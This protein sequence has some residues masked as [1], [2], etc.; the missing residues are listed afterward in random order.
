MPLNILLLYSRQ[1]FCS[2][3]C[4]FVPLCKLTPPELLHK[5]CG[6]WVLLHNTFINAF[7]SLPT[8]KRSISQ[9]FRLSSVLVNS[10]L[11]FHSLFLP[12]HCWLM[13]CD[14]FWIVDLLVVLITNYWEQ[15]WP[16]FVSFGTDFW[17][18]SNYSC[19]CV[20]VFYYWCVLYREHALSTKAIFSLKIE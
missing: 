15:Q 12:T 13:C 2:P 6:R 19:V 11:L 8:A 4:I 16:K 10:G 1:R 18:Q 9:T 7:R 17:E 5:T 20:S 3:H 14:F